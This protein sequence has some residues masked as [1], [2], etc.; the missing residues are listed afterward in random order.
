MAWGRY[1]IWVSKDGE[2][3]WVWS[4]RDG[5]RAWVRSHATRRAAELENTHVRVEVR[6]AL[7]QDVADWQK[8]TAAN[9]SLTA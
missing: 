9:R 6:E 2:P 3:Q 8:T 1:S 4:S 5:T 7:D